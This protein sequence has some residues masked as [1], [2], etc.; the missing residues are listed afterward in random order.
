MECLQYTMSEVQPDVLTLYAFICAP[1]T[2]LLLLLL[3][4]DICLHI[5]DFS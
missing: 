1:V 5:A 4:W 2:I 3:L